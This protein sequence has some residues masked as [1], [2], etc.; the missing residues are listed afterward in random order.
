MK[1]LLIGS[2]GREHVLA[3]KIKQSPLVKELYCAPGNGGLSQL[4]E[5][6]NIASD[7]IPELLSFARRKK[8]DLTIVGPEAPLVEGIVDAFEKEG[9]KIFGPSKRAAQLEGSKVFSKEFMNRCNVPTA[10]FESFD[11]SFDALQYLK[12]AEYPLVIKAEGLASGKGV[13]ICKDLAQAEKVIQ[14]M[15][16]DKIFKDAGNRIVVEEFLAGDEVSILAISDGDHYVLLDSA[17]DH[18]KIFDDDLG[19]NTGGMGAYSPTPIVDEKL[20]KVIDGRVIDPVIRGMKREGMFFKGVLYAGLMLTVDGPIVLEFNVRF[21]DPEAQAILPRLQNDIVEVML[22]A[23]EGRL[24]RVKLSWDKRACVCVVISSGGYPGKYESGKLI[25]GLDAASA[26]PNAIVFHAGTEKRKDGI[27]TAGG[28]VLG[29]VGLGDT[30]QQAIDKAYHAVEKI[31]FDHC[32]FRRDIGAKALT[33][34]H[35]VRAASHRS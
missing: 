5:C 24:N 22:A 32:F 18:K 21:G 7:N 8:I 2:G 29:V 13:V 3:W 1:I 25:S 6:V 15:M 28:R 16:Q 26:E 27:Y 4:A 14:M 19:P 30:V 9:L 23:C 11:N 12:T 35:R 34:G 17:Q 33:A 20:L 10:A 31:K